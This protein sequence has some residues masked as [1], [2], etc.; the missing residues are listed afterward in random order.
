MISFDENTRCF[1][2]RCNIQESYREPGMILVQI[3]TE[4]VDSGDILAAHSRLTRDQARE[5]AAELIRL[6]DN[7]FFKEQQFREDL[8]NEQE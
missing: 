5:V 4:E 2:S 8:K 6:A 1:R 3:R 7:L